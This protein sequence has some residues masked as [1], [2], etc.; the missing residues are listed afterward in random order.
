MQAGGSPPLA[1]G[2]LLPLLRELDGR[3]ARLIRT[4]RWNLLSHLLLFT[5]YRALWR[6]QRIA[7]PLGTQVGTH[8]GVRLVHSHRALSLPVFHR[9]LSLL[10]RVL[11][12]IVF[13]F[14][15]PELLVIWNRTHMQITILL[16][17]NLPDF[18][19]N[20]I[21]ALLDTDPPSV[22]RLRLLQELGHIV[23]PLFVD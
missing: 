10:R 11:F 15:L 7:A 20:R 16:D 5:H 4:S 19:A 18:A 14:S 2:V 9:A 17:S 13:P 1:L 3:R 22:V 12:V 23:A 6:R 8:L 21:L